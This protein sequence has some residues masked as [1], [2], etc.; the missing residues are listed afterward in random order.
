MYPGTSPSEVKSNFSSSCFYGYSPMGG[1]KL[2]YA[3]PVDGDKA[4]T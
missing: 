3:M 2:V 1:L 4:G